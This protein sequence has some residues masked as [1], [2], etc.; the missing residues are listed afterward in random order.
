MTCNINA[1]KIAVTMIQQGTT[2]IKVSHDGS[3]SVAISGTSSSPSDLQ[4]TPGGPQNVGAGGAATFTIKSKKVAGV[5]YVTFS[6]GCGTKA[7]AVVVL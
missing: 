3:T 6:S 4:V 5:Y 1:D 2:T 7:V